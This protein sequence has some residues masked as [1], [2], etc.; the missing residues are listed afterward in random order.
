MLLTASTASSE[1]L[2]II[3]EGVRTYPASSYLAKAPLSVCINEDESYK[4]LSEVNSLSETPK[5]Y[6]SGK[7]EQYSIQPEDQEENPSK[8]DS[9]H[10]WGWVDN[11]LP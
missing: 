3:K 10:S 4:T 9:K 2:S 1:P 7:N 8:S 6:K 11:L 5:D